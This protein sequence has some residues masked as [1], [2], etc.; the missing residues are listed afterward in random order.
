MVTLHTNDLYLVTGFTTLLT[1]CSLVRSYR[2]VKTLKGVGF[3]L[4]RFM[5]IRFMGVQLIG[6]GGGESWRFSLQLTGRK[7]VLGLS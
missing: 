1:L 5:G 7:K 3:V 2:V 6:G 4:V